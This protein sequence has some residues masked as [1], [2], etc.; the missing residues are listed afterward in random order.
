MPDVET[1]PPDP[2]LIVD[3]I[4]WQRPERVSGFD[5]IVWLEVPADVRKARLVSRDGAAGHRPRYEGASPIYRELCDPV[6]TATYV[7]G[8]VEPSR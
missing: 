7:L 8:T 2:V 1:V 6:R 3:G 5:V 4:F